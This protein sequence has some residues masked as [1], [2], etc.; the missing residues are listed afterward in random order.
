MWMDEE[1]QNYR[2]QTHHRTKF[3]Y[4]ISKKRNDQ[5]NMFFASR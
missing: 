4:R 3:T 1:E 5:Y 2:T